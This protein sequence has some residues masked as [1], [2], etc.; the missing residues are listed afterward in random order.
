MEA[1]LAFFVTLIAGVFAE[2][3]VGVRFNMPG[4]GTV[5]AV[6]IMGAIIISMIKKKK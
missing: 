2:A 4:I 1:I 6:A 5:L 3:T